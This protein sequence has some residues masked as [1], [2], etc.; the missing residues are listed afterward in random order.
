MCRE[1][2]GRL[3]IFWRIGRSILTGKCWILAGRWDMQFTTSIGLVMSSCWRNC[4]PCR[5]PFG[6]GGRASAGDCVVRKGLNHRG[7]RGAQGRRSPKTSTRR[8]R[9]VTQHAA[10][11]PGA[12]AGFGERGGES[13]AHPSGS[14]H[15]KGGQ[16]N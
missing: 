11:L 12:E 2:C 15:R 10:G 14:T 5:T 1:S 9:L 4:A 6:G 3:T 7:Q 13:V 16:Q 8:N